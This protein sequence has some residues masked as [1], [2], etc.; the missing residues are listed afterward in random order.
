MKTR[1]TNHH[2]GP[3]PTDIG[4]FD[5]NNTDLNAFRG[6]GNGGKGP[7]AWGNRRGDS[8]RRETRAKERQRARAS[9]KERRERAK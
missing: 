2:Q 4:Q 8:R 5:E 7:T 9:P 6:K 1:P 3:Q